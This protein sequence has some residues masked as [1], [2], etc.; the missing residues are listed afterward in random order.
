MKSELAPAEQAGAHVQPKSQMSQRL[1]V[2]RKMRLT[3][4]Q[5]FYFLEEPRS[6]RLDSVINILFA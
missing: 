1:M 5:N 6:H 2:R 3:L 4:L